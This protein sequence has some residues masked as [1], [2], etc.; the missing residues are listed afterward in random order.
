MLEHRAHQ[1]QQQ[2][3]QSVAAVLH[4]GHS[5]TSSP[6]RRCCDALVILSGRGFFQKADRELASIFP[7]QMR[8]NHHDHSPGDPSLLR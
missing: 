5:S 2:L 7:V 1:Q 6:R 4:S 8:K 3:N